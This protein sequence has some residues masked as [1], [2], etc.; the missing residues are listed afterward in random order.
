MKPCAEH[1][2]IQALLDGELEPAAEAALR[3]HLLACEECASELALY[4]VVFAALDDTPMPDPPPHL[5]ARILQKVL[6]SEI[7]RRWVRAIGWGYGISA[8][9]SLAASVAVLL[10]PGPRAWLG[11]LGVEASQRVAQAAVFVVDALAMALVR[12]SGGWTLVQDVGLRLSPVVRAISTLLA[13]PGVD[14]TLALATLA[15][16]G[17]M[18]WLRPR[19]LQT[20]Q[21][22]GPRGIDHAG[23]LAL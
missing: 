12:V 17:L 16:A 4:E 11:V 21:R 10:L 5:T 6:P 8:A 7:R 1:D 2:R 15:T 18:V 23:L 9:A 19:E 14:V 3:R 20:N 22:R 13:R